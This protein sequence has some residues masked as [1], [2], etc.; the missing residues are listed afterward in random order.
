[1]FSVQPSETVPLKIVAKCRALLESETGSG[2]KVKVSG[3]NITLEHGGQVRKS[4]DTLW[5][6][7]LN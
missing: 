4:S 3:H 1:M 6:A 2:K 7:T 5:C